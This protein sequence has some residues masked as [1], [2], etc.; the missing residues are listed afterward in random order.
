M[1]RL[2]VEEIN[3]DNMPLKV[4]VERGYGVRR[5]LIYNFQKNRD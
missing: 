5:D 1:P 4:N 3:I 2:G